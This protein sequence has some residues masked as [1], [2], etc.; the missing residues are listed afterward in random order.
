MKG[1]Y[2]SFALIGCAALTAG[3]CYAAS[4]G[5][6]VHR[7]SHG[8]TTGASRPKHVPNERERPTSQLVVSHQMD[9]IRPAHPEKEGITQIGAVNKALAIRQSNPVRPVTKPIASVRYRGT[10]PPTI[11]GAANSLRTNSARI[12]GTGMHRKP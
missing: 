5:P 12:S 1:I 9:V 2:I 8:N 4:S 7:F 6:I 3:T 11:G 10:N